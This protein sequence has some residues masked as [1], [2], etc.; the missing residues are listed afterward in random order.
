RSSD[1]VQAMEAIKVIAHY[2]TPLAGKVLILDALT[3]N[4]R[5]MKLSKLP[6]CPTC[7]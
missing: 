4:W 3:M 6:H 5:E 7:S 1:L 2:G